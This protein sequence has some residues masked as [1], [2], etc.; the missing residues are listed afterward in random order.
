MEKYDALKLE[1]QLCFPLYVCAKGIVKLYRP[2][3]KPLGLTYTQYIAMMVLWEKKEVTVSEMGQA[4]YLDS[5]TLTPLLKKLEQK[6]LL[7][8]R[9]TPGDG[10]G[11][12][13]AI[14]KRGEALQ[15]AAAH[16]PEQLFPCLSISLDQTKESQQ[17]L[18]QLM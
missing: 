4:L 12:L 5:G 16:V 6:G 17:M 8:R 2:Y 14:T 11:V 3:L 10:R 15:G 9:R 1:N 7:T 13:A 18:K